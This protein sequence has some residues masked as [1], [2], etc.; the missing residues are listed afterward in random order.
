[1]LVVQHFWPLPTLLAAHHLRR[2]AAC[3]YLRPAFSPRLRPL[4]QLPHGEFSHPANSLACAE[5][6]SAH[7][8]AGLRQ[9]GLARS[10]PRV[11]DRPGRC[12]VSVQGMRR[13]RTG[14]IQQR[15]Q[16]LTAAQILEEG[17]AFELG[18]HFSARHHAPLAPARPCPLAPAVEWHTDI[19]Q[20]GTDGTS[21]ASAA[22]RAAPF[23]TRTQTCCCSATAR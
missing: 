20:R 13:G 19:E 4:R 9:H 12:R 21:T 10:L 16:S 2:S 8:P 14:P 11:A 1:M 15:A 7:A 23:S 6:R 17:K 3:P 5:A 18:M 22:T